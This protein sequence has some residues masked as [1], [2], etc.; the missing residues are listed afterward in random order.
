MNL[1][2]T[3]SLVT[4]TWAG[5][6]AQYRVLMRSL[7]QSPL[8][9]LPHTTIVQTEDEP[10]LRRVAPSTT[11]MITT[12]ALL[13]EPVEKRRLGARRLGE[14]LGRHA[15]RAAG[16][17]ARSLGWPNWP[18]YT[19]WHTQ[20]L[21]KLAFAAQAETDYVVAI[22]SDVI[23]TPRARLSPLVEGAGIACLAD[24]Q[25]I[26][27]FHGKTRKWVLQADRLF[28]APTSSG[29]YDAYFDT[30]FLLHTATVRRLLGW[31]EDRCNR[32]W[33]RVLLDQPPRRWSEFATY[34]RFLQLLDEAPGDP[35]VTWRRPEAMHYIFDLSDPE[36]V[37]DEVGRRLRDR[38]THFITVHSQSSGR[39]LWS[40]QALSDRL[41]DALDREAID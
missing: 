38:Q 4:P 20:Q 21:C 10:A 27:A 8:A 9:E 3:I 29:V 40:A 26:D 6:V 11:Q 7:A 13:P 24:P 16:S 12:G 33:W 34:K 5:D 1:D 17:L 15:T 37:I 39:R 14:R 23:V 30:P 28:D 36:Q 19:G 32:P 41:L 35:V 25:P 22:D 18:R 2:R 31:L